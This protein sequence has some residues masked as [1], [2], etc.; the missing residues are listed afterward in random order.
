MSHQRPRSEKNSKRFSISPN[1]SKLLIRYFQ[2]YVLQF[3]I[4]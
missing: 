2:L 3:W 4:H 1:S